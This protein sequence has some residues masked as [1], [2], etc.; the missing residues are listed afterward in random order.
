MGWITEMEITGN[1]PQRDTAG[2][3]G[4]E[5]CLKPQTEE[6]QNFID[7]LRTAIQFQDPERP[8]IKELVFLGSEGKYVE[9][10]IRLYDPHNGGP[11]LP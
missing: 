10:Y 7:T 2:R 11:V 4:I 3:W 6:D 5:Y 9:F 8:Q 1:K